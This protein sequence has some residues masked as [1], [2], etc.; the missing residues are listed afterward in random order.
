[1]G[2]EGVIKFDLRYRESGASAP[3]GLDELN[4][5][6]S[7]LRKLRLIGQDPQRYDGYGFGNVS[8][9]CGA[10]DAAPGRRAFLISGTQTGA[11]PELEARHYALVESYDAAANRV[12]AQGPVKP[13]SESLTHGILYDLDSR[14]RAVLHVHSNDIWVSADTLG[15]PV[16]DAAVPYG[17][18]AMATEV[19]RL[20]RDSDVLRQQIFS[21][22]GHEDG[23]VAFG[24]TVEEAGNTLL[25]TLA[26]TGPRQAQWRERLLMGKQYKEIS[27]DLKA[28][29]EAQKLFFVGTAAADGRIN[30]SPKGLDS[31]RVI[32]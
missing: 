13:S 22:G 32:D 2:A 29:I 11:L 30:L 26:R 15:I 5:W 14:I 17:T 8:V 16:T 19:K 12:D 27:D 24:H 10:H 1:M 18:P 6:R 3:A 25:S 28:F 9:R 31:L 20:F 4:A 7:R 23:I 21:M